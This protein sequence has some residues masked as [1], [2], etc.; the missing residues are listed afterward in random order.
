M[1]SYITGLFL[2]EDLGDL[3]KVAGA[4]RMQWRR[5]REEGKERVEQMRVADDAIAEHPYF[6]G[7]EFRRNVWVGE[8][9]DVRR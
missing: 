4:Q 9:V 6:A 7:K 3:D 2:D 1:Q 5:L 8:R